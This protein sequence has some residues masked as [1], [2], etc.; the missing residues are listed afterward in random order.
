MSVSL[1]GGAF[2]SRF[3]LNFAASARLARALAIGIDDFG[4]LGQSA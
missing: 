1:D 3:V 2:S 4:L